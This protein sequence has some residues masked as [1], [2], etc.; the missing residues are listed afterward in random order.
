M[1]VQLYTKLKKCKNKCERFLR[2]LFLNDFSLHLIIL[3]VRITQGTEMSDNG[4]WND[5]NG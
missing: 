3:R 1:I 5:S 4:G 2:N